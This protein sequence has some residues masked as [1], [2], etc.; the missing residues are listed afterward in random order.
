MEILKTIG[1]GL[2]TNIIYSI[3]ALIGLY[4][5]SRFW[6]R[7][8]NLYLTGD[9]IECRWAFP[10]T[11]KLTFDSIRIRIGLIPPFN[12]SVRR[13][14]AIHIEESG[15]LKENHKYLGSIKV[16]YD[17]IIAREIGM[18]SNDAIT[19]YARIPIGRINCLPTIM[20]SVDDGGNLI[21][22]CGIIFSKYIFYLILSAKNPD[23]IFKYIIERCFDV[24]KHRICALLSQRELINLIDQMNL[25]KNKSNKIMN[26]HGIPNYRKSRISQSDYKKFRFMNEISN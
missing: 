7:R 10:E 9:Y 8:K 14:N 21:S 5:V 2:V 18:D 1:F 20:V 22:L 24:K 6:I 11:K 13:K 12:L 19:W 15:R 26:I 16:V 23:K 4:L 25:E 3:I 17:L